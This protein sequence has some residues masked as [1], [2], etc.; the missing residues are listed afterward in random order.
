MTLIYISDKKTKVAVIIQMEDWR[1]LINVLLSKFKEQ[2]IDINDEK[3]LFSGD[4]Y[5]CL[6]TKSGTSQ[7]SNFPIQTEESIIRQFIENL[8]PKE[9]E[10]QK[11]LRILRVSLLL[12]RVIC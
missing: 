4:I 1:K 10:K 12:R 6:L 2:N 11:N 3:E 5:Y 9:E 7:N 8:Y